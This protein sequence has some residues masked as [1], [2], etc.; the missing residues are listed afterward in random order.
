MLILSDSDVLSIR[1]LLCCR[2][3]V[4]RLRTALTCRSHWYAS[5]WACAWLL[6]AGVLAGSRVASFCSDLLADSAITRARASFPAGALPCPRD[7]CVAALRASKRTFKN[8]ALAP[9][10][11][12]SWRSGL[13]W[14]RFPIRLITMLAV[15]LRVI[16]THIR[17]CAEFGLLISPLLAAPSN[18]PH[19]GFW[20]IAHGIAPIPSLQTATPDSRASIHAVYR[21]RMRTLRP[22]RRETVEYRTCFGVRL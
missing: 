17:C 21:G 3:D 14:C 2:A 11:L 6:M 1:N 4:A 12:L 10:R 18:M 15:I 5:Y 19:Y 16:L 22:S 20:S 13:D 7:A 8:G 9:S